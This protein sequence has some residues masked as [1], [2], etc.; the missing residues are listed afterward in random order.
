M[1]IIDAHMHYYEIEGFHTAA[2]AAGHENTAGHYSGICA[3][4]GIVFSVAMGNSEGETSLFGGS[5]PR[6]PNLARKF[7]FA[8]FNQPADIGYCCGVKSDELTPANAEKTASE[9]ERYV[10]TPHCVGIKL[11]P[12][13]RHVYAHD[14]VHYPLFELARHYDLP[15]VIHTGDTSNSAAILKYAHPLTVDELAV[16]YSDVRFVLAHCGNPW[17]VDAVAVAD[18]NDNVFI[19]LSGLAAGNFETE[20]FY[21]AHRAYYEHIAMWLDYMGKYEKVM[22]GSDW[23]LV[24]IQNYIGLIGKIIPKDKH[25]AVFYENALKVFPK[26]AP[27]L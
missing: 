15:V 25:R 26:I 17:I 2:K 10:K 12:G 20:S 13:Y 5:T 19:D 27:L 9:F 23:P 16:R 4:N 21:S 7:D 22:Y 24:N 18:K 3:E 1:K 8:S 11:Y 6:V 14:P